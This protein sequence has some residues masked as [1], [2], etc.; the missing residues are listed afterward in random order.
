MINP[1]NVVDILTKL[2]SDRLTLT[3]SPSNT[4]RDEEVAKSLYKNVKSILNCTL[5]SFK[6]NDTLDLDFDNELINEE[7]TSDDSD[8]DNLH[9]DDYNDERCTKA[10]RLYSFA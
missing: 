7:T 5:Y 2:V 8:D 4:R 10:L 3:S 9:D 6:N 1:H